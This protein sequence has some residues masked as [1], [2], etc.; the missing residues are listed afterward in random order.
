[1]NPHLQRAFMLLEQSRHELAE[2]ELRQTLAESPNDAAAHG[3]LAICLAHRKKYAEAS[4]EA[5]NA[6]HL[7]PHE[8]FVFYANAVVLRE[9]NRLPEA[10]AAIREAIG[11]DPYRPDFFALLSQLH[12]GQRG[13]QDALNAAE[14]GLALDPE[15]VDCSNLRAMSLVKLGRKSQADETIATAL[16]RDP[17]DAFSHANMGWALIEQGQHQKAMEHFRE[18]LR[19][20]PELEWARVGIVEAMKGRYFLYRIMLGY[21][22]W[23]IKLSGRMQWGV[24]VGAYIGF[25]ML[26]RVARNNPDLA[27]WIMPL[28]IVYIAFVIMTWVA[29]PLFNLLL[30]LNRFGR[31]ALSREQIVTSNWV[32][33]C[34]LGAVSSLIAYFATGSD[35]FLISALVS[36]LMIPSL[37]SVYNCDEGWPRNW[38]IVITVG[39][40]L[41][42]ALSIGLM[43]GLPFLAEDAA[44]VAAKLGGGCFLAFVLSAIASQFAANALISA[45]PRH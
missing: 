19:L 13:W 15:S 28:L 41:L 42:G 27:P 5:Q 3:V 1:M 10:E 6:I 4:Q 44:K 39:L 18:A 31:L 21:F 14:Q 11:L 7:A 16:K 25:V 35:D 12:F 24:I 20:N 45:R 36:G 2:Q 26:R 38:M 34:V 30:R 40:F 23:M 33:L 37:T 32:G 29:N 43:V 17:E 9:R 8:P 22:L